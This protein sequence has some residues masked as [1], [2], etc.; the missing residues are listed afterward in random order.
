MNCRNIANYPTPFPP[1]FFFWGGGILDL[2]A[3]PKIAKMFTQIQN[4][5]IKIVVENVILFLTP[6]SCGNC[7]VGIKFEILRFR[8]NHKD[9]PHDGDVVC[10]CG[11]AIVV[12]FVH[13][14]RFGHFDR[15]GDGPYSDFDVYHWMSPGFR[16]PN[17]HLLLLNSKSQGSK[18]QIYSL[19]QV[20][21]RF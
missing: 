14:G 13:F 21:V 19:S 6:H 9:R 4:E 16:D 5:S 17:S 11:A 7:Y 10:Q 2:L 18:N 1:P 8:Y 15:F 12:H 20:H 3:Y